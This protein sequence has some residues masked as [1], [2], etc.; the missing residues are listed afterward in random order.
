M[1][2]F[3][4]VITMLVSITA[5]VMAQNAAPADTSAD[6]SALQS[7]APQAAAAWSSQTPVRPQA[8]VPLYISFGALQVLDVHS[9]SRALERG[10]FESN[11][12]MSGFA[13][14]SASLIAVKAGGAAVA[15]WASEQLW[16][17][18]RVAAIG[19]MLAANA[20]MA[21]VVQHNYRA[22]R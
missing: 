2:R 6:A 18:N 22:V 13:G 3:A 1:V 16:K 12:M 9:T 4:I 19:F 7:S 5:P 15:L 11:P 8:L 20:G 17:N 14:N 21:W 10:A